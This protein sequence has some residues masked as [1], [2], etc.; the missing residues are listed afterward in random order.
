VRVNSIRYGLTLGIGD[1]TSTAQD[2]SAAHGTYAKICRHI[3]E[4]EY[5]A[6]DLV[7]PDLR[8]EWRLCCATSGRPVGVILNHVGEDPTALGATPIRLQHV[9]EEPRHCVTVTRSVL[10]L[11][12]SMMKRRSW[13]RKLQRSNSRAGTA[14]K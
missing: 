1:G 3:Y 4:I 12:L 2:V 5:L 8:Q 10:Q 13:H 14:L 9:R 7:W 6:R 11:W